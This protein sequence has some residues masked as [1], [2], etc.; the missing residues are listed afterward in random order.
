ML[1]Y[2]N[3]FVL[4]GIALIL[5]SIGG[6]ATGNRLLAEPGQTPNPSASLIYLG[7][8]ILMLFNGLLS[9]LQHQATPHPARPSSSPSSGTHR[10]GTGSSEP[11]S[12][13]TPMDTTRQRT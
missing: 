12:A 6:F 3:T 10:E 13:P 4:I 1:R 2:L 9:I 8:G 11:A 5:I 7:A